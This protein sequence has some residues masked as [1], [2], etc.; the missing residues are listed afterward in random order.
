MGGKSGPA[1]PD[2]RGAAEEQGQSSIAAIEAQTK[3]NRPNQYTP[4]GSSEW[5]QD[6]G[7][8]WRQD[9]NLSQ[10]QQGALDDQMAITGGR[11]AIAKGMLG[12]A[13]QEM[14]TPQDF[15][16]TLPDAAGGANV[17]DFYGQGL[18]QMGQ[19]PDPNAGPQVP[20]DAPQ[21]GDLSQF[22]QTPEAQG[23]AG[24]QYNPDFAKT[25]YDRQMSLAQPQMERQ[26][27]QLETLQR[28]E[29]KNNI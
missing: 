27:Q 21:Y 2:Y 24:S 25:Q 20:S 4:F 17:P 28:S 1:A 14:D 18:P 16:N 26:K 5:Q 8:N 6:A 15:W 13:N 10:G 7:G 29:R 3:A 11:S 9:I 19:F 22:G 12:R 23:R